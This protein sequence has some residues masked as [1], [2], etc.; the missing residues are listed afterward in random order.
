[1]CLCGTKSSLRWSGRQT[2]NLGEA[3]EEAGDSAWGQL[4][5]AHSQLELP[6]GTP[7]KAVQQE[8]CDRICVLVRSLATFGE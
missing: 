2:Q 3:R 1:M 8:G 5:V 6:W 7:L 4:V